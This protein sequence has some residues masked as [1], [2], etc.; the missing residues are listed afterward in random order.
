MLRVNEHIPLR[1]GFQIYTHD[2]LYESTPFWCRKGHTIFIRTHMH[3]FIH[4]IS[5]FSI[6]YVALHCM[7]YNVIPSGLEES[8]VGAVVP[9]CSRK[10]VIVNCSALSCKFLMPQT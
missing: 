2:K 5:G 8:A 1:L 9:H 4:T 7:S 10:P 3:V 6:L